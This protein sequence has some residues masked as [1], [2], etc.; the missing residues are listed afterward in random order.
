MY[1]NPFISSWSL[2]Q[3]PVDKLVHGDKFPV[4]LAKTTSHFYATNSTATN[5]RGTPMAKQQLA[6]IEPQK[7]PYVTPRILTLK[8]NLSFASSADALDDIVGLARPQALEPDKPEIP[9]SK[10]A[11]GNV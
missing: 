8:V 5:D 10:R 4:P 11:A 6:K 7:A 2:D 3:S 9:Q 1:S